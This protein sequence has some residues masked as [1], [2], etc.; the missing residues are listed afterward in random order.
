MRLRLIGFALAL[1]S[2][3]FLGSWLVEMPE[4]VQ[5][6][7]VDGVQG[8]GGMGGSPAEE[9]PAT[10][11]P[12]GQAEEGNARPVEEE[13]APA[14]PE[15]RIA[16]WREEAKEAQQRA[17]DLLDEARRA[18]EQAVHA[19]EEIARLESG[20]EAPAPTPEPELP[21]DPE[22]LARRIDELQGLLEEM[23][24]RQT[25]DEEEIAALEEELQDLQDR[26]AFLEQNRQERIGRLN[27][28]IDE[29]E[30]LNSVLS[31]GNVRDVS[32]ALDDLSERLAS[33]S[34]D[35][36]RYAGEQ[37]AE[38]SA[39]AQRSVEAARDAIDRQ[40]IYLARVSLAVA[41]SQARAARMAAETPGENPLAP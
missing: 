32:A 12:A 1:V 26:G 34:G 14:S 24:S 22:V 21:T 31:T 8:A 25:V 10:Q 16:G 35:A 9:A 27:A 13:Q 40:D 30:S 5:A 33:A 29:I 2:L 15:E 28:G 19:E 3:G 39:M 38:L 20:E 18:Q 37:E 41:L 7:L 36:S 17:A 11:A 4:A 6:A 23:E